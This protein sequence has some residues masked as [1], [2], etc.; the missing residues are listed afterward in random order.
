MLTFMKY[1]IYIIIATSIVSCNVV[2]NMTKVNGQGSVKTETM[3]LNEFN[4][5]KISKGWQVTLIP[6]EE[7]K[8]VIQANENLLELLIVEN[9]SNQLTVSADEQIGQ[10]DAKLIEIYYSSQLTSL[11]CSAGV[12]LTAGGNL[13]FDDL[14]LSI[15][16]GSEVKLKMML[17]NL[18]L[19]T[20]SGAEADL[21][22]QGEQVFASSSSGSELN[23]V[24]DVTNLSSSASS[25]SE[26][27]LSGQTISL[28]VTTSSGSEIEA[29]ALKA[30]KVVATASSG[31]SIDVYP[32]IS[33]SATAS[34]GAGI[35]YHNKPKGDLVVNKSSGGSVSLN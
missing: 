8:L 31:S 33:L 9:N 23:L 13:N 12:D 25:G 16:S 1:V 6:A 24:A 17:K 21:R 30:E 32:I 4:E 2:S 29:R 10:A 35:E 3:S 7:N 15:S 11:D 27:N 18:D 28:Q 5:L 20:S 34:S 19:K 26:V 22:V 14:S